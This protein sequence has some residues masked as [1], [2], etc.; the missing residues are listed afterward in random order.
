VRSCTRARRGGAA[1]AKDYLTGNFPLRL[2]S[3]GKLAGFLNRRVFV[4]ATTTSRYADRVR[5][6]TLDDVRATR[7]YLPDALVQ[8]VVGRRRA[9]RAGIHGNSRP[10]KGS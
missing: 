7:K 9:R 5:A 4:S 3:T 6:V 8:V 2:D 1:G 10:A